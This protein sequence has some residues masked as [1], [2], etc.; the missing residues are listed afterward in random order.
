MNKIQETISQIQETREE[1]SQLESKYEGG[2]EAQRRTLQ[3]LKNAD[4]NYRLKH[5]MLTSKIEY[6]QSLLELQKVEEVIEEDR[7]R[8]GMWEAMMDSM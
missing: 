2:N 3:I 4:V 1:L 8:G 7:F 5:K 6:L